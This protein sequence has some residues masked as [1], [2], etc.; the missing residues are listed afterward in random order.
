M[1][2]SFLE[3][4]GYALRYKLHG[5]NA[6]QLCYKVGKLVDG[7]GVFFVKSEF[8][9]FVFVHGNGKTIGIIVKSFCIWRKL[10]IYAGYKIGSFIKRVGNQPCGE[11]YRCGAADVCGT[12]GQF[13]IGTFGG[14]QVGIKFCI[15]LYR[16]GGAEDSDKH[17]FIFGIFIHTEIITASDQAPQSTIWYKGKTEKNPIN[18]FDNKP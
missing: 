6:I 15:L 3:R 16:K 14:V 5:V 13:H 8:L 2:V 10:V 4:V 18:I 11:G 7:R 9:G 1:G 17:I 12:N